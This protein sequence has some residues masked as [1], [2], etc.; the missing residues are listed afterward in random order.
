MK[1]TNYRYRGDIGKLT[2]SITIRG[3]CIPVALVVLVVHTISYIFDSMMSSKRRDRKG[4]VSSAY[5]SFIGV[6][7]GIKGRILFYWVVVHTL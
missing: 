2:Y 4:I 3:T 1:S 6:R 7:L 5:T